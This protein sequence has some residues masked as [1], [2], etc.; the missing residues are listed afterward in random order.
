MN[1]EHHDDEHHDQHEDEHH[2]DEY[3]YQHNDSYRG[4]VRSTSSSSSSWSLH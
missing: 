1:D 4:R 3:H 2:D